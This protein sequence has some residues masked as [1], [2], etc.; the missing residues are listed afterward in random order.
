MNTSMNVTDA[1]IDAVAAKRFAPRVGPSGCG[2]AYVRF[3][4]LTR[5]QRA[6]LRKRCQA[7]GLTWL[8]ADSGR[9]R[10]SIYVGYD[11]HDGIALGQAKAMAGAF[12]AHG[13]SCY[14]DA[15]CD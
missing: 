13:F 1:V 14:D 9:N 12:K 7:G 15:E 8:G 2:R 3:S 4:G 5:K 10:D 11:N 6:E